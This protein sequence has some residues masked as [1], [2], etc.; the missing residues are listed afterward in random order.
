MN[1]QWN[2]PWSHGLA[3]TCN[4][5]RA[6]ARG[7]DRAHVLVTPQAPRDDLGG[8]NL[9]ENDVTAN[10]EL[11]IDLLSEGMRSIAL[12]H[13]SGSWGKSRFSSRN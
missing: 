11:G 2:L 8:G 3:I 5:M 10:V 6:R 12:R 7:T 4:S 13:M 1:Q 9:G